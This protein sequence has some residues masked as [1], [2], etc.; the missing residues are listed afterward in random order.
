MNSRE[1]ILKF[2]FPYI[3][4]FDYP[5]YLQLEDKL[6]E[7]GFEYELSKKNNGYGYDVGDYRILPY[8]GTNFEYFVTD[9]YNL[10]VLEGSLDKVCQYVKEK[11]NVN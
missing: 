8:H 9:I 2:K 3:S 5:L 10:S 6:K 11:L 4:Q 1:M 7:Y